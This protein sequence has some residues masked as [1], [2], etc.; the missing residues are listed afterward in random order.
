MATTVGS[1]VFVIKRILARNKWC[2]KGNGGLASASYSRNKVTKRLL[3]TGIT[4]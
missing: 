1:Q 3:T 4:P 2:T